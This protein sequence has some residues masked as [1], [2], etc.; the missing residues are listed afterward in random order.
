MSDSIS[1]Q[2]HHLTYSTSPI[3]ASCHNW[4]SWCYHQCTLLNLM[5]AIYSPYPN[6]EIRY[7]NS[8]ASS[9]KFLLKTIQISGYAP[10]ILKQFGNLPQITLYYF[11]AH[12]TFPCH[13]HDLFFITIVFLGHLIIFPSHK[14]LGAYLIKPSIFIKFFENTN[15]F[16]RSYLLKTTLVIYI[17][18]S[19]IPT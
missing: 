14:A 7:W 3:L 1:S 8:L 16:Q 19:L 10:L 18:F 11:G 15:Y 6:C 17:I 9:F 4:N 5:F 2:P 13:H 12:P